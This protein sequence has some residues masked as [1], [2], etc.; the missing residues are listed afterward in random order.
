MVCPLACPLV[1]IAA[2]WHG[3]DDDGKRPARQTED[4]AQTGRQ[5]L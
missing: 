2:L 1:C 3:L 5:T 4:R